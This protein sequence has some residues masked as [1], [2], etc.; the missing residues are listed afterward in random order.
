MHLYISTIREITYYLATRNNVKVTFAWIT[1]HC[2]ILGN[3]LADQIAC[4]AVKNH[5]VM[6]NVDP[7]VLGSI[8][9]NFFL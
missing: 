6:V 2:G 4:K 3:E 5:N 1:S 7:I 9:S 8:I